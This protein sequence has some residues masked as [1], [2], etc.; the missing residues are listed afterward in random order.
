TGSSASVCKK[1]KKNL[2]FFFIFYYAPKKK[3][4]VHNFF[5]STSPIMSTHRCSS[6]WH[7]LAL[8]QLHSCTSFS[9]LG[10]FF[11]ILMLSSIYCYTMFFIALKIGRA[12]C[13]ER[14]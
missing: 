10:R 11:L 9:F 8:Q 14:V 12:S 2:F 6:S 5:Y 4:I 13:R 3:K 7:S 1:K